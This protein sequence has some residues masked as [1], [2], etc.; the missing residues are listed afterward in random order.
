MAA[1]RQN[2]WIHGTL[3]LCGPPRAPARPSP[4]PTAGRT[5]VSRS[6]PAVLAHTSRPGSCPPS[7]S[8]TR[9]GDTAGSQHSCLPA[10]AAPSA[11]AAK[12]SSAQ[13]SV[14]I[15]TCPQQRQIFLSVK[16]AR[17]QY[18]FVLYFSTIKLFFLLKKHRPGAKKKKKQKSKQAAACH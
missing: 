4:L 10:H 1:V 5:A 17:L 6:C 9:E 16:L 3:S 18:C 8:A 13:G 2:Q 12:G 11:V 15:G 7:S 14:D